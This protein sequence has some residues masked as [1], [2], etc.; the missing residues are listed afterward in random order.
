MAVLISPSNNSGWG[1]GVRGMFGGARERSSAYPVHVRQHYRAP[2]GSIARGRH[3][4]GPVLEH[5]IGRKEKRRWRKTRGR[6]IPSVLASPVYANVYR[7]LRALRKARRLARRGRVSA[8][9][10]AATTAAASAPRRSARISGRRARGLVPT[11]HP[12]IHIT[13][14][15]R[16]KKARRRPQRRQAVAV[17]EPSTSGPIIE[18]VE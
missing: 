6:L 13:R 12:S 15:Y 9:V 5:I 2:W 14:G 3:G 11:Y 4:P 18:E 16:G 17:V 8:A 1:L 7:R 10:A